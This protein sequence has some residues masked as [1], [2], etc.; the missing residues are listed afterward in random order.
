MNFGG[1]NS[2]DDGFD[3][4]NWDGHDILVK[5]NLQNNEVKD[6]LIKIGQSWI[7]SYNIDGLRMDAA[8]V[9]DK[10]F[11][12]MLSHELKSYKNN[13]TFIGEVVHGNY[14]DWTRDG[15]A[16]DAVTNYE[17]YKGLYSS[18][19]DKNYYEIA[20]TLDRQFGRRGG[21]YDPGGTMYNFVDNHDVNRVASRL[22][23]ERHL[24][25][26][27]IMLYTMPGFPTIYYGSEFGIKGKKKAKARM[28]L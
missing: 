17:A 28:H 10:D 5:L 8:D 6:Y 2:F 3:Y 1:N 7:E 13:F 25:P 16:M 26:L 24:Y 21:K 23:E 12:R 14:N 22:K 9:M 27:Y 15:G 20:H 4:D 11:L 18:L 19:N